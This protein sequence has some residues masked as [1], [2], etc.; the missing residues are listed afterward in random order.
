MLDSVQENVHWRAF[1]NTNEP[2]RGIAWSFGQMLGSEEGLCSVGLVNGS[3]FKGSL[4]PTFR[5]TC[6]S[7][8]R[9]RC[10]EKRRRRD[11]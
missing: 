9:I 6:R 7:C 11:V 1:I 8:S 10:K 3:K 5:V 2:L 4:V